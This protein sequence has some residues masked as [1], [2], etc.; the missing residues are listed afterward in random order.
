[1]ADLRAGDV[2][3]LEESLPS[4]CLKN[5]VHPQH[6]IN[7]MVVLGCNPRSKAGEPGIQRHPWLFNKASLGLQDILP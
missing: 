3:Q 5:C 1:M 7:C 2:A 4:T 6:S